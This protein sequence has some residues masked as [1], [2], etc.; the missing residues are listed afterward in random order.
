MAVKGWHGHRGGGSGVGGFAVEV[1]VEV[2]AAW[3]SIYH[4]P[5]PFH[6]RE[7]P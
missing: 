5:V 3:D 2:E 7:N 6:P 1:E 4:R